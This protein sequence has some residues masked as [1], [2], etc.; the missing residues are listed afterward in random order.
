MPASSYANTDALSYF[1]DLVECTS[2]DDVDFLAPDLLPNA[3]RLVESAANDRCMVEALRH[4]SFAARECRPLSWPKNR[5]VR[6]I[7]KA[8]IEAA[9]ARCK[10]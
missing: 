6:R 7:F 2:Q 10:V 4:L 5:D 3:G 8:T 9:S 1:W